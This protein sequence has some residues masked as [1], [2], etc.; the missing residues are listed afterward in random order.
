MKERA[1]ARIEERMVIE[2]DDAMRTHVS[3]VVL[4][5]I[6]KQTI[7][8]DALGAWDHFRGVGKI[9]PGYSDNQRQAHFVFH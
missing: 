3:V 6:W 4:L 8:E 5:D 9:C 2:R 7:Q 1:R